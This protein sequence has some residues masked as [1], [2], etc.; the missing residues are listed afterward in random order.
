MSCFGLCLLSLS[1]LLLFLFLTLLIPEIEWV[2]NCIKMEFLLLKFFW[3]KATFDSFHVTKTT[4]KMFFWIKWFNSCLLFL[5]FAIGLIISS[6]RLFLLCGLWFLLLVVRLLFFRLRIFF[7]T[8]NI[9]PKS[10]YFKIEKILLTYW[11]C[12]FLASSVDM[13]VFDMDK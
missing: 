5:F 11:S 12:R 10:L 4:S 3:F 7:I 2:M 1:L 6:F 8:W 9:C 13:Y